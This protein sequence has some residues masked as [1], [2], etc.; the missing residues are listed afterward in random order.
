[1]Q[2]VLITGATDGIGRETARQLLS[3]GFRVLVHGRTLSSTASLRPPRPRHRRLNG[4]RPY[5]KRPRMP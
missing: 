2:T 3:R 1:M 5:G 4:R